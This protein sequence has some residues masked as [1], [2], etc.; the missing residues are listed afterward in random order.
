MQRTG[1]LW[2]REK[3]FV[4]RESPEQEGKASDFSCSIS[5]RKEHRVGL[6]FSH[7]P[8]A[9]GWN[10]SGVFIWGYKQARMQVWVLWI[11][12]MDL[13]ACFQSS[14]LLQVRERPEVGVCCRNISFG[15]HLYPM[16]DIQAKQRC[17]EKKPLPYPNLYRVIS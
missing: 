16:K 8:S 14:L 15:A 5:A 9:D 1:E 6:T 13:H 10:N 3:V 11:M 4:P 2:T 12:K 7:S 17:P